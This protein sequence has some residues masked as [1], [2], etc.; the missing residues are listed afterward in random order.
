[1]RNGKKVLVLVV[2][3]AVVFGFYGFGYTQEEKKINEQFW[4][5]R[6]P[7]GKTR[8]SRNIWIFRV[9]ASQPDRMHSRPKCDVIF[10]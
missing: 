4:A 5:L 9:F 2:V 6:H 7:A 3:F 10:R 1:M 8:K